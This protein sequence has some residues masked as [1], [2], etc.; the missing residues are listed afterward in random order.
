MSVARSCGDFSQSYV[1]DRRLLR[2]PPQRVML[3]VLAL[4]LIAYPSMTNGEWLRF[5]TV[6]ATT[7]IAVVGLQLLVGLTGL[8]SVGQS[9]FM[10]VGAYFAGVAANSLHQ[11]LPVCVV[12]GAVGSMMVGLAFGLP[13]ARIKGFYLAL[14][15]LAAQYVFAF[16]IVRLPQQ[17]FGGDAGLTMP[18]PS[19]FGLNLSSPWRLYYLTIALAIILV[20]AALFIQESVAGHLFVAVR[21]DDLAASMTGVA[22]TRYRVLAFGISAL[23]AGVA[24]ALLAYQDGFVNAQAFSVFDSVFFL[25]MII[26]G[27]MGTVL[28]AILGTLMLSFIQEAVNLWGGSVAGVFGYHL[29]GQTGPVVNIVTGLAICLML[30]YEPRGLAFLYRR[31][32]SFFR[33]WPFPYA[34]TRARTT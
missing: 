13:A 20:T 32:E 31:S 12:I 30:I 5:G 16:V 33:L 28:G 26:I 18:T 29:N 25:G 10:G 19:L 34:L 7:L 17:E 2:T 14:T 1:A 4:V 27:G 11:S 9:A 8:V 23:Y 24:G 15:T 3:G 6:T 21:D 22:V